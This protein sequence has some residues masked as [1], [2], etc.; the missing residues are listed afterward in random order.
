MNTYHNIL[1]LSDP[2]HKERG[3]RKTIAE[4]S[5]SIAATHSVSP[6]ES[7]GSKKELFIL[8][9]PSITTPSAIN[10]PLELV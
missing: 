1:E 6:A 7:T 2:C 10:R 5:L 4:V 8:K 3:E 9:I